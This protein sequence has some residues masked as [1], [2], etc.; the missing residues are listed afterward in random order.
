LEYHRKSLGIRE[1]ILDPNHPELGT[2]HH[3]VANVYRQL[4]KFKTAF[5]HSKRALHIFQKSLPANDL[6]IAATYKTMGALEF[7]MGTY[8][9]GLQYLEQAAGIYRE[10]L[11]QNHPTIDDIHITIMRAMKIMHDSGLDNF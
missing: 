2:S 4:Q 10:K 7:D 1:G 8:R 9:K 11:P 3:N 5:V 6:S